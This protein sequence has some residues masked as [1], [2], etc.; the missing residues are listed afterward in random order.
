MSNL[1]S[2][3]KYITS[4]PDIRSGELR[5]KGRRLTVF[6]VVS[7]VFFESSL[8]DFMLDMEVTHD[9]VKECLDFCSQK[10]CLRIKDVVLCS[11]CEFGQIQSGDTFESYKASYSKIIVHDDSG[12]KIIYS[13]TG[14]TDIDLNHDTLNYLGD[15]NDFWLELNGYKGWE[16]AKEV[17]LKYNIDLI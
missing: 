6:D 14:N 7:G 2:T 10:E 17:I 3:R 9:E 5:L 11:K 16:M 15:E 13:E 4:S 12:P 8:N 1:K